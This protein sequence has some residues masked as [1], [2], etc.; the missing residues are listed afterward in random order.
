MTPVLRPYVEDIHL[1]LIHVLNKDNEHNALLCVSLIYDFHKTYH[2]HLEG[3]V[4]HFLSF[5]TSMYQNLPRTVASTFP[6]RPGTPTTPASSPSASSMT[7]GR[8]SFRVLASC[9]KVARLIMQIYPKLAEQSLAHLIPVMIKA[10]RTEVSERNAQKLPQ[11]YSD[12]IVARVK[13]LSFLTYVL[14]GNAERMVQHSDDLSKSVFALLRTCPDD[15][16]AVRRELL[17]D[18]R[19]ML[20]TEPFRR[21]FV[22]KVDFFL[23]TYPD[24]MVGK[25]RAA[26]D[27]LRPLAVSTLIDLISH[28][29]SDLSLDQLTLAVNIFCHHLH[30]DTLPFAVQTSSAKLVF[31]LVDG[32]FRKH[33]DAGSQ[34]GKARNVL[35]GILSALVSKF[36]AI[37]SLIPV[38]VRPSEIS[39]PS[40]EMDSLPPQ[41]PSWNVLVPMSSYPSADML[42]DPSDV[43]R[44][45]LRDVKVLMNTMVFGLK[46]LVWCIRNT[47]GAHDNPEVPLISQFLTHVLKC[48]E[49]FTVPHDVASRSVSRASEGASGTKRGAVSSSATSNDES[50]AEPVLDH[51]ASVFTVLDSRT[52]EDVFQPQIGEFVEATIA[53][54]ATLP[55]LV[56]PQHIL[57]NANV[58]KVFADLLLSHLLLPESFKSMSHYDSVHS[59]IRLNMFR[60][61]L[62]ALGMFADIESV[63]R[64]HLSKMV[65]MSLKY[66]LVS[67]DPRTYLMLLKNLFRGIGGGMFER[68]YKEFLPVMPELLAGL[69]AI[70]RSTRSAEVRNLSIE[71]ALTVPARLSSLL[72]FIPSLMETVAC[73]LE[74]NSDTAIKLGLR[75]LE[76]WIDNLDLDFLYPIIE[77]FLRRIM[78]GLCALL[79]PSPSPFGPTALHVLGALS[80]RNRRFLVTGIVDCPKYRSGEVGPRL[81]LCTGMSITLQ[82]IVEQIEKAL[83]VSSPAQSKPLANFSVR[84]AADL[85]RGI[86]CGLLLGDHKRRPRV[87]DPDMASDAKQFLRDG[88]GQL[89]IEEERICSVLLRSVIWAHA[90]HNCSESRLFW[91]HITRHFAIVLSCMTQKQTPIPIRI[92][93]FVFIDTVVSV[94]HCGDDDVSHVAFTEFRGWLSLLLE[95]LHALDISGSQHPAIQ[96]LF[97][98][99]AHL[100]HFDDAHSRL[101]GVQVLTELTTSMPEHWLLANQI[102]LLRGLIFTLRDT[103]SD[104]DLL[105]GEQAVR[106]AEHVV[107]I[108]SNSTM[109]I[110]ALV[111]NLASDLTSS[112]AATRSCAQTLLSIVSKSRGKPICELLL[113]FKS[114]LLSPVL[115]RRLHTLAPSIRIGFIAA[116]SYALS[117]EPPL[118]EITS[119]FFELLQSLANEIR[120][121]ESASTSTITSVHQAAGNSVSQI[122]RSRLLM[123]QRV[124]TIRLLMAALKSPQLQRGPGSF[125]PAT[126]DPEIASVV[127]PNESAASPSP[128]VAPEGEPPIG[129]LRHR[130]V[131]AFFESLRSSNEEVVQAAN[132]GMILAC[133]Q[134]RPPKQLLQQCLR[135]VLTN[136][137]EYNKLSISLLEMLSR[138]LRILSKCFN[139]TL[140][141]KLF[142]HL[143]NFT[144]TLT[145]LVREPQAAEQPG[146]VS[147]NPSTPG[148]AMPGTSGA[149][150]PGPSPGVISNQA[151]APG[152]PVSR[153]PQWSDALIPAAIL[154]T[155]HLL[156]KLPPTFLQNLVM[157][158]IQLEAAFPSLHVYGGCLHGPSSPF[159]GPLM[160]FL[161]HPEYCSEAA[162]FFI[163]PTSMS[164]AAV[165]KLFIDCLRSGETPRLADAVRKL[166]PQLVRTAFQPPQL[167]DRSGELRT[168][169]VLIINILAKMS[170]SNLP[171][172]DFGLQCLF[173]LW[174]ERICLVSSFDAIP[175]VDGVLNVRALQE[176]VAIAEVL[177]QVCEA[178]QGQGASLVW[179]M[180]H[181][182]ALPSTCDYA[183]LLD[184]LQN[185]IV[186][187]EH[188]ETI[189]R[190]I[191][192][193][194]ATVQGKFA[195]KAKAL[196]LVVCPIITRFVT[197]N[198]EPAT[199]ERLRG[200]LATLNDVLPAVLCNCR[201]LPDGFNA[202][203][204]RLCRLILRS[205]VHFPQLQSSVIQ[206]SWCCA[207]LEN[208]VSQLDSY[209]TLAL[210]LAD[211]SE[212][213]SLDTIRFS[214]YAAL[215]QSCHPESRGVTKEALGHLLP[216]LPNGPGD[217]VPH[218]A[219]TRRFMLGEE[220]QDMVCV[221]HVL[222]IVVS[223][224]DHF[225]PYRSMLTP[226]I[227]HLLDRVVSPAMGAVS[228]NENR[229]L[230]HDCICVVLSWIADSETFSVSDD[231]IEASSNVS[232]APPGDP[233]M[234][235][236]LLQCAPPSASVPA[237]KRS[238][239]SPGSPRC[240]SFSSV[241]HAQ[242]DIGALG[243]HLFSVMVAAAEVPAQRT[244]A[245]RCQDTLCQFIAENPT[246][247]VKFDAL[248]SCCIPSVLTASQQF[249][250]RCILQCLSRLFSFVNG[251]SQIVSSN[252]PVLRRFIRSCAQTDDADVRSALCEC[253]KVLFALNASDD[254]IAEV[255]HII[256]SGL[257]LPTTQL[258]TAVDILVVTIDLDGNRL[259]RHVS[260]LTTA[261]VT[262]TKEFIAAL[263]S[264]SKRGA[265]TSAVSSIAASA[266]LL[267]IFKLLATAPLDLPSDA[268]K[269]VSSSL[270]L[271]VEKATDQDFLVSLMD[272]MSRWVCSALR[273]QSGVSDVDA[274]VIRL[275]KF[276]VPGTPLESAFFR[277]VRDISESRT[278][279]SLP[280]LSRMMLLGLSCTERDLRSYF[281]A[282][283][284]RRCGPTLNGFSVLMFIFSIPDWETLCKTG[285]GFWV[286]AAC[287]LLLECDPVVAAPISQT[288][289]AR[290]HCSSAQ[291]IPIME[292]HKVFL[293]YVQDVNSTMSSIR[294]ALSS[295]V[296][297][298]TTV[299]AVLWI[300]LFPQI[301]ASA[302]NRNDQV[303]LQGLIE[304]FLVKDWHRL[305]SSARPNTVQ[306]VLESILACMKSSHMEY[307]VISPKL[308]ASLARSHCC[309]YLAA[310][311]LSRQGD[312]VA[313][314]DVYSALADR[315]LYFGHWY[316][317]A[318]TRVSASALALQQFG[319]WPRA[320]TMFYGALL[321]GYGCENVPSPCGPV[322]LGEGDVPTVELDMWRTEWIESTKQL[323][324]W[325]IVQAYAKDTGAHFLQAQ[326]AWKSGDWGVRLPTESLSGSAG[327]ASHASVTIEARL[328]LICQAICAR[329][330]DVDRHCDRTLQILLRAWNSLPSV[331]SETHLPIL[332]LFH[333]MVEIQESHSM[334]G[335]VAALRSQGKTI[336]LT[337]QLMKW[338]QRL[339]NDWEELSTWTDR[340]SWR[341]HVFDLI[342]QVLSGQTA[343]I[344]SS[345]KTAPM[346]ED[347]VWTLLTLAKIARK[348]QLGLQCL[349]ALA[350]TVTNG[351]APMAASDAFTRVRE[352]IRMCMCSPVQY[353][354]AL[355]LINSINIDYF[356][357]VQKAELFRLKGDALQHLGQGD[358]ANACFSTALYVCENHGKSWLSWAD[359]CDRVFAMKKDREWATCAVSC[360]MHAITYGEARARLMITRVIWL[361]SYD[362]EVAPMPHHT[363]SLFLLPLWAWLL[364]LPQ[365]LT[366]LARPEGPSMKSILQRI[367]RIYPQSLHYT[368]RA[369]L[370]EK[371]E[372]HSIAKGD[373]AAGNPAGERPSSL[374]SLHLVESIVLTMREN[375]PS[376]VTEIE[377]M[378]EEINLRFQP[379]PQEELL[380]SI[381]SC[382][383][384]AYKQAVLVS[385][386]MGAIP[387]SVVANIQRIVRSFFNSPK[388]A[389]N[390]VQAE[391]IRR[392]RSVFETDFLSQP[393]M[394]LSNLLLRLQK[395]KGHL[396]Y[397]VTQ[398]RRMS[399]RLETLSPYLVRFQTYEVEIPGQYFTDQEPST[400]QNV[401][402][403][404]FDPSVTI[405]R[406]SH[407]YSH[408]RI[409]ML[410]TD[411]Q[412]YYFLVQYSIAHITRS[413]ERMMQLYTII[414]RLMSRYKETRRRHL[415]AVVPLVVPL[416]HRLRLMQT[417]TDMASLEQIYEQSCVARGFG[418]DSALE[419]VQTEVAATGPTRA[420]HLRAFHKIQATCVPPTAMST[421]MATMVSSHDMLWAYRRQFAQQ[422]GLSCFL[423]YVLRVGDRSLHKTLLSRSTGNITMTEFY[424]SYNSSNIIETS[425]AVP[426]R[427]SPN[428]S[429]FIGPHLISGVLSSTLVSVSACLLK[430]QDILKN[431]L[432][433]FIR[434]DLV[435]W[436]STKKV[437]LADS[438]QR[439]L[440]YEVRL[441]I[442]NNTLQVLRGIQSFMASS[443]S[444]GGAGSDTSTEPIN[445]KVLHLIRQA[446][447]E[448]YLCAQ[449]PTWHP[450]F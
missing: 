426:F 352:Q 244:F 45:A 40:D 178:T 279:P 37:R 84:H 35:V 229:Q 376:L 106:S 26:T 198:P 391:F 117:I 31:N 134:E 83:C 38:L 304:A 302:P 201:T 433:L 326:A 39:Q 74:A 230:A 79:R 246:A 406:M 399:L 325:D 238:R 288:G 292:E 251:A 355:A 102:E 319:L 19:H 318:K 172:L 141:Q 445:A 92:D 211:R 25:G 32:I 20:A 49:I 213:R 182:L 298:D 241:P 184:F 148:A 320:Q 118:L 91:E 55:M 370:F 349:S 88:H 72:P 164:N 99:A 71:L 129:A 154:D 258:H 5:F 449:S 394:T 284:V 128:N 373:P 124:A 50:A 217:A 273:Y 159:R 334:L 70:M 367:A 174:E 254:F 427:L 96:H 365:L 36:S 210:Y 54:D 143:D 158:V 421:Y 374:S 53:F 396:E 78:L 8:S 232:V 303:V 212:S 424:P 290:A 93:P 194:V 321:A 147:S 402:I 281:V 331:V 140:A 432:Y 190:D 12:F 131:A 267:T 127:S 43:Y 393:S 389:T 434:D 316:N 153:V 422:M 207:R 410:G 261:L 283:A 413:D 206:F 343:S 63:L 344:H 115:S 295:S 420:S 278:V 450:W 446:M 23:Q 64:P 287:Q 338:R 382:F 378:L 342:S 348:Q 203:L 142:E 330:N 85:A 423:A 160:R 336:D 114:N 135:P 448:E 438:A 179:K 56:I 291:L 121:D 122:G 299:A 14:R 297:A 375:H 271:L 307:P 13:T 411:G 62:G 350:Q 362:A 109:D 437:L 442:S 176:N 439:A 82:T 345:V 77:K 73:A 95:L 215:V 308:L 200:C 243:T 29:R 11:Q 1:A 125:A 351:E 191:M 392:Y 347:R 146:A 110:T 277:M 86:L 296:L 397:Q 48:L 386:I 51:F 247:H 346:V 42:K 187:G 150:L 47:P 441:Q 69:L 401:L 22:D 354:D 185:R 162:Y 112:T 371:R 199:N 252:M 341:L 183:F 104:I 58:S 388:Q 197:S 225:R 268:Q 264:S 105:I 24:L 195:V 285:S 204:S 409:G 357:N 2:P 120:H 262:L 447:K 309:W 414:N 68:L 312:D 390:P 167:T 248:C 293:D 329:E 166:T 196:E 175:P 113:P 228:Q 372:V 337:P 67:R 221:R 280:S 300:E 123:L 379:L 265:S 314:V 57:S 353:K 412:T 418:V 202:Q 165:S 405:V 276:A 425:D 18:M 6:A 227:V 76:F 100:C 171:S 384:K 324:Q 205:A 133:E 208:T 157:A 235:P 289:S 333:S 369:F 339:P 180:L 242:V 144:R 136:F 65:E 282:D 15:A 28:M 17:L 46:T 27:A 257:S 132:E 30:D 59:R 398:R 360:Y 161:N 4:Q 250:R 366:C 305:Q 188:A 400:D 33:E 311:L 361:L 169:G 233:A 170:L 60:I 80:G 145:N 214:L 364:W 236:A 231:T 139:V 239:L 415:S 219:W 368:V 263:P 237:A 269:S 168:Q 119:E 7:L 193:N 363:S 385:G 359:F 327:G 101:A 256:G 313:L 163:L 294:S 44:A 253:I 260:A 218:I 328:F 259:S 103:S 436:H 224:Q 90:K 107:R 306:V 395:W 186:H 61:T 81:N 417:Q 266:P 155:F 222:D 177:V 275:S 408:R 358:D 16:V 340:V 387:E 407:S 149:S 156:P 189:L 137:A 66:A 317:I 380:G 419:V 332:S 377:N 286:S 34:P 209:Q 130:I 335:E 245:Q 10:L 220:T 301:W 226:A 97:F 98:K 89:Y 223:F 431:Y 108:C 126:P 383:L 249:Q 192:G 274:I 428:L 272:V 52:F 381:H 152:A 323:G 440:E 404:R 41:T 234:L 444:E 116:T 94:M 240:T 416:T 435:S 270:A 3:T 138:L 9:E 443:K 430:H 310:E 315:D 181:A 403:V 75:T 255:D 87:V 21:S 322:D 173:S 429:T 216:S 356:T 151:S 111:T